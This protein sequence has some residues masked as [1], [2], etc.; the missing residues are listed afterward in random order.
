MRM[1]RT[2]F[3]PVVVLLSILVLLLSGFGPR[4]I[5]QTHL[6]ELD[7]GFNVRWQEGTWRA[8][9]PESTRR[10]VSTPTHIDLGPSN[11][12]RSDR[13][14]FRSLQQLD[15]VF[16]K[17]QDWR[18]TNPEP[19]TMTELTFQN[20]SKLSVIK[21]SGSQDSPKAVH[22]RDC[23]SV[24][25]LTI[26][27]TSELDLGDGDR[28]SALR[29]LTLRSVGQ[30]DPQVY[31]STSLELILMSG[32]HP[33]GLSLKNLP[34]LKR[35]DLVFTNSPVQF[36][37]VPVGHAL[38]DLRLEMHSESQIPALDRLKNLRNLE[39]EGGDLGATDFT[40]LPSLK[41][42]E[43]LAHQ[44]LDISFL[45]Q[46]P[47]L[48]YLSIGGLGLK[49]TP[50]ISP[51]TRLRVFYLND[52]H[53][54]ECTPTHPTL[55]HFGIYAG[56]I[57]RLNLEDIPNADSVY[58]SELPKLTKVD[59]LPQAVESLELTDLPALNRLPKGPF[60]RLERI[61]LNGDCALLKLDF[62]QFPNLKALS[63]SNATS[64]PSTESL[65]ESI[66]LIVDNMDIEL[67]PVHTNEFGAIIE[68]REE[69]VHYNY[70]W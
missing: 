63:L 12:A 26:R 17:N 42:L 9:L 10:W 60:P 18:L 69:M 36:A 27:H 7:Q 24:S 57:E 50:D 4:L 19:M 55:E 40:A 8:R 64:Y 5:T 23:P 33:A 11:R 67:P 38:G 56:M 44:D 52:V 21:I 65:K 49:T 15:S 46:L 20:C 48:D 32:T 51:I 34:A 31:D 43:L 16:W 29:N 61:E 66:S 45:S 25:I 59:A 41:S 30:V 28:F 13:M 6:V 54:K 3:L 22:I 35:L 1:H 70:G 14:T 53:F 37:D 39:L 62:S 2:C 47:R 68:W 58:L